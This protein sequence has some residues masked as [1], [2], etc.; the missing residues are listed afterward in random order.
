MK[1]KI[2]FYSIL[3]CVLFF[4]LPPAHATSENITGRECFELGINYYDEG[5]FSKAAYFFN[6]AIET[7]PDLMEAYYNLGATLEALN[8]VH[9]AVTVYE[10]IIKLWPQEKEAYSRLAL[11]YTEIDNQ[12]IADTYQPKMGALGTHLG[13]SSLQ[14]ESDPAILL[15]KKELEEEAIKL[16]KRLQ[17]NPLDVDAAVKLGIIYRKLGQVDKSIDTLNKSLELNP[18]MGIIYMQLGICGYFKMDYD[19][20]IKNTKR[21]FELGYHAS[22]SLHDL[23]KIIELEKK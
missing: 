16:N 10:G 5:N 1:A 7:E 21:A 19:N 15:I 18:S 14:G 6:Q 22:N 2:I 17:E 20:F 13:M 12:S 4:S 3:I 23:S 11:L 8:D 9:A